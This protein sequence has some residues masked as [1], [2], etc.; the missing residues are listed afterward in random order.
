[1]QSGD[2]NYHDTKTVLDAAEAK[3]RDSFHISD[4]VVD[5]D[6]D[7]NRRGSATGITGSDGA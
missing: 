6:V 5:T 7:R 4:S 1:M 3:W 2:R